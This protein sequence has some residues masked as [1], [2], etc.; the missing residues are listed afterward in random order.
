MSLHTQRN[1]YRRNSCVVPQLDLGMLN[2]VLVRYTLWESTKIP[3]LNRVELTYVELTFL[4]R[5]KSVTCQLHWFN[6]VC[7]I[8][9]PIR[10]T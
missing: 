9:L 6:R 5:I 1:I 3:H 8:Y 2:T 4:G 10:D 7:C